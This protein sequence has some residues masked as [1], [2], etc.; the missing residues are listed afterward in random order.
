M[1]RSVCSGGRVIGGTA[2]RASVW[3]FVE[4]TFIGIFKLDDTA[5][6]LGFSR[7]SGARARVATAIFLEFFQVKRLV[8]RVAFESAIDRVA[9]VTDRHLADQ[10]VHE[11]IDDCRH[12][13][14]GH[15]KQWLTPGEVINTNSNSQSDN[16]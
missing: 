8:I 3:E 16:D 11:K 2:S 15:R 10:K 13:Q 6:T 7:R 4:F 9:R 12:S 5:K 1:S 14:R